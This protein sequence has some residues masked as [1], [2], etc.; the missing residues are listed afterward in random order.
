MRFRA[1]RPLLACL[2]S[3]PLTAAY[4]VVVI[5]ERF[6]GTWGGSGILIVVK[7][8]TATLSYNCGSG[9]MNLPAD[10]ADDGRFEATGEHIRGG[11]AAPRA[12]DVPDRHPAHYAGHVRGDVMTLTVLLTDVDQTLGTFQ[13]TRGKTPDLLPCP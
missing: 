13:L 7:S 6:D 10:I 11:G 2:S 9:T 12:G 5:G 4:C 1:L 3:L 8:N